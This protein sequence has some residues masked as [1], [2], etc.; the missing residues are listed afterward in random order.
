MSERK[1]WC[2]FEASVYRLL[3]IPR[4]GGREQTGKLIRKMERM[5]YEILP[6]KWLD[7]CIILVDAFKN[8]V[9]HT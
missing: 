2:I 3:K 8:P 1:L 7:I 5:H 4:A 6:Y 9:P